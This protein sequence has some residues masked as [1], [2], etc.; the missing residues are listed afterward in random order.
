MIVRY[1]ADKASVV[2]VTGATGSTSVVCL[3]YT[4]VGQWVPHF[5]PGTEDVPN[6]A[7]QYQTTQM[8]QRISGSWSG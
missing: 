8:I 7:N 4:A 6:V 5:P 1:M 2:D 3:T